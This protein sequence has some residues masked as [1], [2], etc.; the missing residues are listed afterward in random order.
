M[1]PSPTLSPVKPGNPD[2]QFQKLFESWKRLDQLQMGI[3]A[4]PS[5]RPAAS[6]TISSGFG[7]PSSEIRNAG[8]RHLGVDI[9]G[10]PKA[11][12]YATADGIVSESG[13][14]GDYGNLVGVEHGR[15]IR[16]RYGHLYLRL[17]KVGDRVKRGQLIGLMG[18]SGHVSATQ[19]HYEVL[20]DGRQV[21]PTPFLKAFG[22]LESSE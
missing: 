12:I 14:F 9:V 21:N 18:T 17:V 5:I 13:Q 6:N 19:L 7:I 16:T 1:M 4:I 20:I 8:K 15:G 11:P 3:V 22:Y 10:P 2:P